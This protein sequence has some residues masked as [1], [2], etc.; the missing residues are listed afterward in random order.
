M[1]SYIIG[2]VAVVDTFPALSE[3]NN[4]ATPA[5]HFSPILAPDRGISKHQ[6]V[7]AGSIERLMVRELRHL[8][9]RE[10]APRK[11]INYWKQKNV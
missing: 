6:F 8:C 4:N 11:F 7:L 3:G 9:G 5:T 10:L 2:R 1:Q